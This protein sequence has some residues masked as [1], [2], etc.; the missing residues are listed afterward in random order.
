MQLDLVG[1]DSQW[2]PR[3]SPCSQD[4]PD[5][6]QTQATVRAGRGWK[7]EQLE[8]R[9]RHP[10]LGDREGDRT[11]GR[12]RAEPPDLAP[13]AARAHELSD[14]T[15]DLRP[16]RARLHEGGRPDARR[17]HRDLAVA[18]WSRRGDHLHFGRP[19]PLLPR[20]PP[21]P[22]HPEAPAQRDESSRGP[23]QQAPRLALRAR[24]LSSAGSVQPRPGAQRRR[25]RLQ[26]HRSQQR[27]KRRP[28][29]E[30]P[31]RSL[32]HRVTRSESSG[33]ARFV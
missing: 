33:R 4:H 25:P 22:P 5:G 26:H 29:T 23:R 8:H 1:S 32:N 17:H 19:R 13:A 21:R 27:G 31:L 14:I 15:A 9:L 11:L 10:R 7:A 30:A 16:P 20:A 24:P 28:Q 2:R 12:R 3:L 6:D 18:V